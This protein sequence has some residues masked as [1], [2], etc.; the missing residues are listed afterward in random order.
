MDTISNFNRSV[1]VK[2]KVIDDFNVWAQEHLKT[3]A[4]SG[5]CVSWYKAGGTGGENEA[6]TGKE[7]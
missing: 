6:V 4:W 3:T 7:L 1:T 2:D 5:G